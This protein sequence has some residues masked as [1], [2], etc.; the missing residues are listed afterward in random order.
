M[1]TRV[2]V[3]ATDESAFQVQQT[4]VD[5]IWQLFGTGLPYLAMLIGMGWFL[6]LLPFSLCTKGETDTARNQAFNIASSIKIFH[7]QH[8]HYPKSLDELTQGKR[9]KHE[10]ATTPGCQTHGRPIMERLPDDPWGKAYRYRNPGQ[11][12][13][14]AFDIISAGKEGTFRTEDDVGNFAEE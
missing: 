14:E 9:A 11:L 6:F 7:V 2:F 4:H 8:G 13:K 10:N 12:N 1:P 3:T 5:R